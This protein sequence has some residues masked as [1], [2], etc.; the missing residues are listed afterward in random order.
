MQLGR[1][2]FCNK[3]SHSFMKES[4]DSCLKNCSINSSSWDPKQGVQEWA[5]LGMFVLLFSEYM[6]NCC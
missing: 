2:D 4:C 1:C 3:L 5:L 6:V